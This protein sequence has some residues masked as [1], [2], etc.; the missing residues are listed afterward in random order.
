MLKLRRYLSWF[1]LGICAL[2]LIVACDLK[3]NR[4]PNSPTGDRSIS[5]SES[6]RLVEHDAGKTEI[7][8]HPQTVAALSPR[9]LDVMLA[10]DIQPAAYAEA[11]YTD[12]KILDLRKFDN[13]SQQI[14]HLGHLITTQPVNLGHR[15][16]PSLETLVAVKPDLIVA[17]TWQE[18]ELYSQIAP[19]LLLNN[20]YGK[21]SW[22][23]R[24]QIVAQAFGKEEQ[25]KQVI[26]QYEQQLA[27]TR[28]KLA[29]VIDAYPHILP[30]S[31]DESLS[32]FG[33][34]S[35]DSDIAV[36]LE[37]LGFELVFLKDV[38]RKTDNSFVPPISLEAFMQLNPDIILVTM[39]GTDNFYNPESAIA[40]Q[41][42]ETPLLQN[43][44]AVREGRIHF[45]N[46]QLWGGS[47]SGPIAYGI[48]LDRLPKLLLSFVDKQ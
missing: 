7:C 41:W 45:V 29:T 23:R 21:E 34:S 33:I 24:L 46:G 43:M 26:A 42:A 10:L 31:P 38:P 25:A 6:C 2:I 11:A 12:R 27:Q 35:Y 16:T 30:V 15:N 28:K 8:G 1:I 22:S 44:R 47:R 37:E 40:R 3:G 20:Q 4:F 13:P 5:N 14:P 9:V 39:W 17:E 48:M 19:T 36:L 18:N 32:L